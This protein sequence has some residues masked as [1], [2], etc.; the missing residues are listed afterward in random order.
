M[1]A[2]EDNAGA[3][4]AGNM[5]EL[6]RFFLV[7]SLTVLF[8]FLVY[9]TATNFLSIWFAKAL[10]F[11]FGSTFSYFANQQ[12]TFRRTVSNRTGLPRFVVVYCLALIV[13][14]SLNLILLTAFGET[15]FGY[16]AAFTLST[17]FSASI[18][19]IGMKYLVFAP[20]KES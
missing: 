3:L 14:A 2:S 7:G 18:T 5:R 6:S 20:A 17:F 4:R 10:G 11:G 19:Y 13:N 16:A 1:V 12:F 9:L 8:D 15:E